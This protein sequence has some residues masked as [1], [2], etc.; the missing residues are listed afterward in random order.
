MAILTHSFR[1]IAKAG[2]VLMRRFHDGTFLRTKGPRGD[3][4]K[5]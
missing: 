4:E 5:V 2:Y 1:F 3:K